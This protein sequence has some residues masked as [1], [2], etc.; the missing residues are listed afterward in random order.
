MAKTGHIS[1]YPNGFLNGVS[2]RGVPLQQT[3]PGEVFWVNSTTVLAKQGVGGSD[4]NRGTYTKPFSTLDFAVGQCTA[5]RGDI[6]VLMPGFTESIATATALAL[7]VAGI[8]IVGLGGGSLRPNITLTTATTATIA[9]SAANISLKN[10]IFTASFADIADLFTPTAVNMHVE[11]CDFVAS[12]A[13]VNFVEIVDTGT[14]DNQADGLSF[15]RCKWIEP[16]LATTSMLNIDADLDQLTVEDC[17]FN[18]GVN[19]SDLPVIAIVAT[20]KDLSNARIVGNECIRLNDA[21]PLLITADTTTA[22]TGIVANNVVRHLD[23]AGA[24]LVTAGTNFGMFNNDSQSAVDVSGVLLPDGVQ[25]EASATTATAVIVNGDTLFTIAG[26]PIEI[27]SLVSLNIA[28]NDAT[29]S[30]L[31]YSANPTVG[32]ATTFSGASASLANAAAGSAV[33]L[34][35]TALSTAP[36]VVDPL[37]SLTGVHTRGVIV[38]AGII[39]AV[40]GVGSTTGTWE[41]RLRYRPLGTGITVIGT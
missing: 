20:G 6:I 33:V 40:V 38:N 41:H 2:I 22:N 31:Q 9:V 27:L 35:G 14:T 7:D 25:A 34:N 12:A 28:L 21:N 24:L 18:L 4:G 16:D 29:A 32:A 13:N 30:T 1:D 23:T 10:I 17:N 11:D 37:V 26:G 39:T 36:D 19:T 8:A 15:L 3:Q 5:S